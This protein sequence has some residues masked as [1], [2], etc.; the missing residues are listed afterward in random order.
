[1][2]KPILNW[3]ENDIIPDNPGQD[4]NVVT[5]GGSGFGLMTILV[6]IKNGYIPKADAVSRLTTALQFCKMPTDSTERGHIG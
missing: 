1:M 5:T 3:Q 4:A 2:R 6:G